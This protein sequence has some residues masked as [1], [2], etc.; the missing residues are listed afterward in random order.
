VSLAPYNLGIRNRQNRLAFNNPSAFNCERRVRALWSAANIQDVEVRAARLTRLGVNVVPELLAPT[1]PLE[2]ILSTLPPPSPA[3]HG[4]Y[5]A[6]TR[7]SGGTRPYFLRDVEVVNAFM[8]WLGSNIGIAFLH[9]C[10]NNSGV[11]INPQLHWRELHKHS[12]R[13]NIELHSPNTGIGSVSLRDNVIL[14]R[15]V[16]WLATRSGQ[17]FVKV[18]LHHLRRVMK[19]LQEY[20]HRKTVRSGP[21]RQKRN[22]A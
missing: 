6:S 8:Q 16:D 15:C 5:T 14:E 12:R 9:S 20:Q 1:A 3:L 21:R 13:F 2:Y 7:C 18:W 4:R 22:V 10:T 11:M 17:A 19:K